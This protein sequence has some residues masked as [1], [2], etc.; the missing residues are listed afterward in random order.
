[1]GFRAIPRAEF[2]DLC[3]EHG[4]VP[5]RFGRWS[6]EADLAT[7]SAWKPQESRALRAA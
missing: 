5:H 2:T 6:V 7:V 1:M 4:R 3:Q